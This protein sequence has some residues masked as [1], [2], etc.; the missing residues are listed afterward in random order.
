MS[1]DLTKKS[2]WIPVELTFIKNMKLIGGVRI[3]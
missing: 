3:L 1:D 2:L